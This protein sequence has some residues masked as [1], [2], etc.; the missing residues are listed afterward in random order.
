MDNLDFY[1]LLRTAS[2]LPQS[3]NYPATWIGHMSFASWL[4]QV[5]SPGVFVELGTHCGDSYFSFC[6]S[7]HENNLDTK[8]Y[9]VD[10]WQ[11]EKHT[12][13]YSEKIYTAVNAH[14]NEHYSKFSRLLRMTFDEAVSYFADESIELLHIDGLHTYK[15]VRHD[16][17][18][19]LPKLAPGAI[20]LFHDTI[21]RERGF[22][23]WQLWEELQKD[24]PLN[25]EFVHSYGLGVIQL[26]NGP[27]EKRLDWLMPNAPE[28]PILRDYFQA[29][30]SLNQAVV[31]RDA[32]MTR[33][34]LMEIL[35]SR[36][37]KI[38]A[39]LR[40]IGNLLSGEISS[41][42]RYINVLC[43]RVL[44]VLPEPM[45]RFVRRND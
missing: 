14:N 36:S 21:V 10:T 12:G 35:H 39:P 13:F 42:R 25:L 9:A 15:A 2:F 33:K 43:C 28:K 19:W 37:W 22:G 16:F 34:Q 5:V 24:F 44:K 29:L 26:P 4:M 23:V 11:G 17:E 41:A 30:G 32:T 27:S 20:V 18:T 31:E 7:V 45:Q 38:T 1:A 40:F 8:C 6:Q 3:V